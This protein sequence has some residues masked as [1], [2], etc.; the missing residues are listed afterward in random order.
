MDVA[1]LGNRTYL[2]VAGG[3]AVVVDPPR[4][5]TALEAAAE[6]RRARISLVVETH[7]HADYVS[8]GLELSRRHRASYVVPA[9]PP[10]PVF[11]FLPAVDGAVIDGGGLSARVVATPGHTPH[12]VS[13]V[14]EDEG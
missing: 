8:G 13:Y 2:A 10:E 6:G 3:T 5:F 14:L 11:A 7:R 9:G 4:R 12:H 1:G